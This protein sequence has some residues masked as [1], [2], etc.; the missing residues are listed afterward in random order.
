M[1]DDRPGGVPPASEADTVQPTAA[2]AAENKNGG[3]RMPEPKFQQTSGYLPQGYPGKV[4]LDGTA[5]TATASPITS[6]VLA[7]P[8]APDVEVEPQP[9]I[10]EQ[11]QAGPAATPT[12]VKERSTG[13]RVALV[14][15]GVLGMI[16]FIAVF[17]A[18]VYYLFI[19]PQNGGS[20]F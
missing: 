2:A 12:A 10:A 1:N 19:N 7:V 9:D 8:A 6:P 15:L 14:V 3:W 17:L 18:V 5:V 20:T 4:G 13:V 11:L 16:V